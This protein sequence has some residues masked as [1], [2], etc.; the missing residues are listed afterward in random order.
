MNNIE[1]IRSIILS[2]ILK[3]H[4]YGVV[5]LNAVFS[6]GITQ[7]WFDDPAHRSMFEVMKIYYDGGKAFD[8]AV[9]MAYMEK[10]GINNT[11]EAILS[12]MAHSSVPQTLVMEYVGILKEHYSNALLDNVS[13]EISA[14]RSKGATSEEVRARVQYLLDQ[15]TII[16]S[17]AKTRRLSEVR[18]ERLAKP[19]VDRITTHIPFIDTVLTDKHKRIGIRNEGL[20]FVSGLKQSGKT[21]IVTRMME[22][23]SRTHPV[24]FGS[25]EFGEDLY[26]ENIEEQQEEGFFSGNIENIYTFDQIYE[27][28]EI[29]AEIRLMHKLHG[30]KI[31]VLDSMLRITN[32][33][34]DLKTDERRISETFSLLGRLSKEL[35]IPIV[36]VVQSSKE[37]LKSSMISVKGSMSADHEA[38][39][40]FHLSKTSKDPNDELR[41]VI[42][43]KNKDTHKHPQQHLMFVPQTADFY[44]V[45]L[46]E[47]GKPCKALDTFRSAPRKAVEVVY[48]TKAADAPSSYEEE[49][50]DMSLFLGDD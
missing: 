2:S 49:T 7:E 50:L 25:M 21:F 31:V 10:S 12:V 23:I 11:Q 39:V 38:Y 30:I 35:K 33:N 29:A 5:D 34:P 32:T 24:M 28:R 22:N 37:D 16:K 46:D 13:V 48:E 8:D 3:S 27:V 6:S 4:V 47:N 9:I 19:P 43:N 1:N 26:D 18:A 40:W 44:R 36:I 41:T 45:E 17:G 20:F 15:A 42:W 14:L